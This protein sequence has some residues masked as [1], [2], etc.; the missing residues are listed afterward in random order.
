MYA[1]LSCTT[2]QSK[3]EKR[4]HIKPGSDKFADEIIK[5]HS[6]THNSQSC[7]VERAVAAAEGGVAE[8]APPGLADHGGAHE[9]RRVVRREADQDLADELGHQIRRRVRCRRH[10]AG[11]LRSEPMRGFGWVYIIWFCSA[12]FVIVLYIEIILKK[13]FNRATCW[14]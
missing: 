6:R 5:W 9:A 13:L 8:E 10:G 1:A 11:G 7:P 12:C 4:A 14:T 3:L 2:R